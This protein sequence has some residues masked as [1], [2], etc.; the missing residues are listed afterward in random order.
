M[1]RVGLSL[2]SK[3]CEGLQYLPNG[4]QAT[5]VLRD[6]PSSI[7]QELCE[8]SSLV[9][10]TLILYRTVLVVNLTRVAN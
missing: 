2:K 5:N 4:V 1:I 10:Y 3:D 6:G 9:S 8:V 7:S